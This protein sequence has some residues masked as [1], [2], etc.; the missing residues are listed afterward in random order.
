MTL[1]D[2]RMILD[3]LGLTIWSHST[4]LVIIDICW[5]NDF[6]EPWFS[7]W[8]VCCS[9]LAVF[10]TKPGLRYNY[11]SVIGCCTAQLQWRV[12]LGLMNDVSGCVRRLKM[13]WDG[14]Q[15]REFDWISSTFLYSSNHPLTRRSFHLVLIEGPL[16][17][18]LGKRACF[19]F[20]LIWETSY[21]H[22]TRRTNWD[23]A[24]HANVV[25][26]IRLRTA[27]MWRPDAWCVESQGAPWGRGRWGIWRPGKW[28]TLVGRKER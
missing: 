13:R 22:D 16:C 3:V 7:I 20:N 12:M 15:K 5:M 8:Y 10:G 2:I 21:N 19:V 18:K 6:T 14:Y 24:G 11:T 1:K 27:G 9:M 23:Y 4:R 25:L 26:A 17:V 28:W